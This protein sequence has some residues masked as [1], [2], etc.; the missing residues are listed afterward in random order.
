MATQTEQLQAVESALTSL[1]QART[2]LF[3]AQTRGQFEEA[4]RE[5]RT[6]ALALAVELET[7]RERLLHG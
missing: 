7:L 6:H 2:E 5:A 3:A 4:F 1:G